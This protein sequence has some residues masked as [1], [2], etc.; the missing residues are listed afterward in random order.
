MFRHH[1]HHHSLIQKAVGIVVL[2]LIIALAFRAVRR[3]TTLFRSERRTAERA[4]RQ[5]ERRNQRAYRRAARK[6]KWTQ[7]WNRYRQP[8]SIADYE[9]KRALI[10]QQENVL[11]EAMQSDLSNLRTAHEIVGEL[12][13]A[14]EGRARLYY[15][16]NL[17]SCRRPTPAAELGAGVGSSNRSASL[18]TYAAPPP[19]YEEELQGDMTVVDGFLYTPSGTQ[20]T[21]DSSVIDCSP[22][23]SFETGRTTLDREPR[24]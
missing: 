9:E 7:W 12:M 4:A 6:H 11:E 18:P 15:Q 5:E 10:L 21:P 17:P 2:V 23:L 24:D 1:H 8:K 14:E 16:A 3:R 19:M 13:Q 22:R 20:D